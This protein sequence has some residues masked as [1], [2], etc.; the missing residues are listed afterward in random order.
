MYHISTVLLQMFSWLNDLE[1][2]G[3]VKGYYAQ[4]RLMLVIIC[5]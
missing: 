2:I 4:H 1:G 5:A 3:Q